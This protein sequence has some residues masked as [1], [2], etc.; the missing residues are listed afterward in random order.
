MQVFNSRV[1][2]GL[3]LSLF[4]LF[5]PPPPLG[6]LLCSPTKHDF[7]ACKYKNLAFLPKI[8]NKDN[9]NSIEDM[10]RVSEL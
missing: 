9:F 10:S 3:Y 4:L 1:N 8:S 7:I 6:R 5:F 2:A